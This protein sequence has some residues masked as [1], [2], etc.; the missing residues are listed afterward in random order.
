MTEIEADDLP[1]S[2]IPSFPSEET[3]PE[4]PDYAGTDDQPGTEES[5]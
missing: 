2:E 4:L 3:K 1:S 5:D